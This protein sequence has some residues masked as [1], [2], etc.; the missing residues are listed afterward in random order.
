MQTGNES[1]I[2]QAIKAGECDI[3]LIVDQV[4]EHQQIT[5]VPLRNEA[6]SIVV[7]PDSAYSDYAQISPA[8]LADACFVLTE[9]GC[10]YRALLLGALRQAAVPH[11]VVCEFGSLEAIK[12]WVMHGLGIAFLLHIAVAKDVAQGVLKAIPFAYPSSLYTQVIYMQQKWQS[13][14][15][16]RFL[17]LLIQAGSA[18]VCVPNRLV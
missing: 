1:S 4:V 13:Q 15:F 2:L 5:C 7:R 16:Q 3:G 6:L 14:A 9:E 12:Q 17:S 18:D 10:T 8:D 11:D